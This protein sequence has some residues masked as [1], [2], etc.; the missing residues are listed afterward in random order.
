MTTGKLS[1]SLGLALTFFVS[2]QP[3]SP[4]EQSTD[5]LKKEIAALKETLEAIQ[6]DIQ[7]IKGMLARQ[8]G[9]PSPVNAFID[10]GDNPFKGDGTAKLALVEFSDYQ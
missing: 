10:L 2:A 7:D 5:E 3:A 8:A 9:P 4:Q 1:V 6:K